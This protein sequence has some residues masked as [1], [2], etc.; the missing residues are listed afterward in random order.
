MSQEKHDIICVSTY[1]S[2]CMVVLSMPT[3][4]NL[5][6]TSWREQDTYNEMMM[7]PPVYTRSTGLD[8]FS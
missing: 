4:K 3:E 8:G 2:D 1:I 5:S 6:I 7:S